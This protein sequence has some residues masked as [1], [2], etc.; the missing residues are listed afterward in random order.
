MAIKLVAI[1]VDKTL[2]DDEKVLRPK[3]IETIKKVSQTGVKIVI[4][5]GRPLPGLKKI[6]EQLDL[7]NKTDQY[8]VCFGGSVVQSTAGQVIMSNGL[9]YDDYLDLELMARKLKLPFHAISMERIYTT[10]RDIGY[11]SMYE[12][13]LV[14]MPLSY[15]TPTELENIPLIK[16]MFVEE[17][18]KLD[19]AIAANK[20]L[21]ATKEDTITFVKSQPFFLEANTKGVDKAQALK[22]LCAHLGYNFEQVMA[23]GDGSNDLPMIK[24]AKIGVAMDNAL[25][26]VKAASDFIIADNNHDGVALALEKYLL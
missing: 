24:A 20:A 17:P 11:Y 1:D 23:I 22:A 12:S 7:D 10:N 13:N 21:F 3:V 14:N 2:V 26:E 16:A 15:R 25:D 8:V 9:D 18:A 6:L 19:Q 5:S 4:C